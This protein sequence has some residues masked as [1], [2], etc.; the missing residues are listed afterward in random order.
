MYLE[1]VTLPV[2]HMATLKREKIYF[3][4]TSQG[5]HS[6]KNAQK[7]KLH[8]AGTYGSHSEVCKPDSGLKKGDS[9]E[10][11][12]VLGSLLAPASNRG[13]IRLPTRINPLFSNVKT[14]KKDLLHDNLLAFDK[15]QS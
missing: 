14:Q 13:G 15:K 1:V 10:G 6:S 11:K 4:F 8:A 3:D 9:T 2:S 5:M 12:G 7:A